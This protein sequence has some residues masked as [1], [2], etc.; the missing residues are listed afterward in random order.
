MA[1]TK[2]LNPKE[3]GWKELY[4][5]NNE[6]IVTTRWPKGDRIKID[7]VRVIEDH[8]RKSGGDS[9][10]QASKGI[11]AT[12]LFGVLGAIA[13]AAEGSYIADVDLDIILTDGTVIEIRT[14]DKRLLKY[15]QQYMHF[16]N[17][18]DKYRNM[19]GQ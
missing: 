4:Y 8:S 11:I 5:L 13:S 9:V 16:S 10:Q 7:H 17:P 15:L 3:C 14:E 12:M 6:I 19:R 2:I 1:V 18:R